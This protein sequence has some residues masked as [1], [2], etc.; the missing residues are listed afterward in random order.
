MS[1]LCLASLEDDCSLVVF[2]LNELR[3]TGFLATLI[4]HPGESGKSALQAAVEST[5][6]RGALNVQLLLLSGA[7]PQVTL[8]SVPS[9]ISIARHSNSRASTVID[10]WNRGGKEQGQSWRFAFGILERG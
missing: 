8:G 1:S 4:D 5:T 9:P 6:P 2:Y 3:T 10:G 7:N